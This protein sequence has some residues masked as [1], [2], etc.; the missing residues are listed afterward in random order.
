MQGVE[1]LLINILIFGLLTG[2][3][4]WHSFRQN[5]LKTN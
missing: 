5:F 2:W 4:S 1:L 3:Q